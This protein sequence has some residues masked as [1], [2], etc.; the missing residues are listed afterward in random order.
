M[1]LAL[2]VGGTNARIAL[3][4][5]NKIKGL[6]SFRISNDYERD[7]A[8]IEKAV[9]GYVSV[10]WDRAGFAIAGALDEKREKLL[11]SVNLPGWTGKNLRVDLQKILGT[12]LKI[13]NDAYCAALAVSE[14]DHP[15]GDF[16]YVNWGTGIGGCLGVAVPGGFKITPAE[17]GH[18][19]LDK[20]G[21][22]CR[23]GQIGC[24]DDLAGG[25]A[26]KKRYLKEYIELPSSEKHRLTKLFTL[27]LVNLFVAVPVPE[28]ILNGGIVLGQKDI[29]DEIKGEFNK[30]LKIL[31]RLPQIRIAKSG[32]YAGLLGAASL[33]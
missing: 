8:N 20:A 15:G 7:L 24:W 17:I 3:V 1:V 14:S 6:Q 13:E 21:A 33:V 4:D 9:K 18:M 10:D 28:I 19:C 16:W 5:Q 25:G 29:L 11:N 22:R 30:S 2:D 26:V 32:Q 27:G 12:D 31:S 23:C